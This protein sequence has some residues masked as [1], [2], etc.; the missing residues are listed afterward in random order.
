MAPTDSATVTLL[1]LPHHVHRIVDRQLSLS[2]DPQVSAGA[3]RIVEALGPPRLPHP[4]AER[5]TGHA[6]CH[7]LQKHLTGLPPLAECRA[8]DIESREVQVLS[9]HAVPQWPPKLV[10]PPVEVFPCV[11]V[12][13]LESS[14]VKI[15]GL[16][17]PLDS[18]FSDGAGRGQRPFLDGCATA[19][20]RP[21]RIDTLSRID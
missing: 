21:F 11:R 15:C 12:H 8:A 9:E 18:E 14:A 2:H 6:R 7:Y 4:G 10:R 3:A 5:P 17:V 1:R 20:L 13:G 19:T 16:F